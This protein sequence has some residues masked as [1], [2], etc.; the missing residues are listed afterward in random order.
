[1]IRVVNYPCVARQ[2][3]VWYMH[4]G[5]PDTGRHRHR[6]CE[7]PVVPSIGTDIRCKARKCFRDGLEGVYFGRRI[8]GAR[9]ESEDSD[10]RAY[11]DEPGCPPGERKEDR[12]GL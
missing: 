11:V 9:D 4:T 6:M 5:P 2:G 3:M 8:H 12:E 10:V 1:M 7:A